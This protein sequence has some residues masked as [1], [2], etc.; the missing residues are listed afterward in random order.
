M[1]T[2]IRKDRLTRRG[3]KRP[4]TRWEYHVFGELRAAGLEPFLYCTAL[5]GSC[6]FRFGNSLL[7]SLR[8]AN[9]PGRE[10]L[11]YRW[12]LRS[13]LTENIVDLSRHWPQF[14]YCNEGLETLIFSMKNYLDEKLNVNYCE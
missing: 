12:Q 4:S 3:G 11:R 7:G 8:V 9:H 5:T 2:K 13:D 10:R 1:M 14:H 6:Y